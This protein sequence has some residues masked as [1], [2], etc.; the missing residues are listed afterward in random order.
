MSRLP[1]RLGDTDS[2]LN[3]R[4]WHGSAATDPWRIL[5]SWHFRTTGLPLQTRAI[6]SNAQIENGSRMI[7]CLDDGRPGRAQAEAVATAGV[8]V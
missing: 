6:R 7:P 2:A 8:P 1:A 5:V 4:G 3:L